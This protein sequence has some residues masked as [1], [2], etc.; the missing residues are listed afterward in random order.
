MTRRNLLFF[1]MDGV[2]ADF[3]K[4]Y[5]EVFNRNVYSDDSFTIQQ[6]VISYPNFFRSLPVMEK[7]RELFDLLKDNYD[8]IFLTTPMEGV[9]SC[10]REKIEWIDEHFGDYNVIFAD[11]KQ[12]FVTDEKSI[13]IDDMERNLKPWADAGGTAINIRDRNDAIID[14]IKDIFSDKSKEI[15]KEIISLDVN[16]KPT[17]KQRETGNYKKGR[18]QF[19][20][21]D[22]V[23]EN[24]RGS[25]RAGKGWAGE[26]WAQ[27][28]KDH[29][30]Y[31]VNDSGQE[32]GDGD[33][34]DCFIGPKL[35]AS[36]AFIVNQQ[37]GGMFD[38]HKVMLGYDNIEEAE[39]AYRA[40]YPKNWKGFMNIVQANTK[41]LRQW[42]KEGNLNEPF[43]FNK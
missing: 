25:I 31:I 41:V 34:V 14:K 2:V 32:T 36:R 19:K 37:R 18:I 33:K 30:G 20:G 13:L 3:A 35:N 23:I 1:D 40:H 26:K 28:M 9:P 38:E 29:Y 8:I 11:N 7:G 10:R 21:L 39:A 6:M 24:P 43:V 42:L 22:I 17:E 12:Q 5:K 15:E 27:R 16:E 4:R